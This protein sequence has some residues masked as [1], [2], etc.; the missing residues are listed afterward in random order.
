MIKFIF[1][2]IFFPFLL[3][4]IKLIRVNTNC[5]M[6]NW[7]NAYCQN[8]CQKDYQ[9]NKEKNILIPNHMVFC[10]LIDHKTVH[11][12]KQTSKY[13]Q[14]NEILHKNYFRIR[15][16]RASNQRYQS[17]KGNHDSCN[18]SNP[19][20]K[21]S[22]LKIYPKVNNCQWPQRKEYLNQ[23]SKWMLINGNLETTVLEI[24]WIF[25]LLL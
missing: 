24:I 7:K 25:L 5:I 21:F 10:L 18:W 14:V 8:L 9:R 12:T 23:W 3:I 15:G 16:N 11:Q 17:N 20:W 6:I 13:L 4:L 1:V 2:F 22:I 19:S